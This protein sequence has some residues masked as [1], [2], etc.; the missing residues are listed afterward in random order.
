MDRPSGLDHA[1][2]LLVR[3]RHP[4]RIEVDGLEQLPDGGAVL[5]VNRVGPFDHLSV[6]SS[7]GRPATVVIPPDSGLRPSPGLRRTNWATDLDSSDHP[8]A[9]LGRGQVLVVFPEGAAG[10]DGAVHKGHAEFVA[11]A[12]AGRVPIVPAALVPLARPAGEPHPSLPNNPVRRML[13]ELRYRLTIGEPVGIERYTDL[14]DPSDTV[15]GLILRGLADLVMTRIS[16]LAGRRYLDNYTGQ[17]I[18]TSDRHA[19]GLG[20]SRH[21]QARQSRSERRAV[22]QDRRAAEEDLARALDEQEAANLSA[23]VEAAR[24]HAEQSAQADELARLRRRHLPQP[25]AVDEPPQ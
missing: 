25:N 13:P 22:E 15:D 8:A 11:A 4:W 12:L 9:V 21:G 19:T 17:P 20:A 1:R 14:G 3:L 18:E 6:A 5:A 16:Q 23:A 24:R 7:L 10:N 2:H